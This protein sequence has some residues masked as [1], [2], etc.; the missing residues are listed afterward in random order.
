[1]NAHL[2]SIQSFATVLRA[3]ALMGTAL[4]ATS[5]STLADSFPLVTGEVLEG[6]ILMANSESLVVTLKAGGARTLTPDELQ[7]EAAALVDAWKGKNPL[8]LK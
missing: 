7:P 1:M 2:S 8:S 3:S 5:L 6:D 4:I